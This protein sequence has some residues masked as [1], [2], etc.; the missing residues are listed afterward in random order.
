MKIFAATASLIAILLMPNLSVADSGVAV[1][2]PISVD[3]RADGDADDTAYV[4]VETCRFAP[5][6]PPDETTCDSNLID[7][8]STE[9][10]GQQVVWVI[11][12]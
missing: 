12:I 11:P 3:L 5:D 4:Q 10:N 2:I 6:S 9:S 8:E 1:T 7:V